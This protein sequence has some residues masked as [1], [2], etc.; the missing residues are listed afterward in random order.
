MEE[1]PMSY[2]TVLKSFLLGASRFL[3]LVQGEKAS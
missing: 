3:S 2:L 1:W